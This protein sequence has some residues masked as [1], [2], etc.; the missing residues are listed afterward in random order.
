MSQVLA[1][2]ITG[3]IESTHSGTLSLLDTLRE[4]A[5][6]RSL[7]R[8]AVSNWFD[9]NASVALVSVP[10]QRNTQRFFKANELD[11]AALQPFLESAKV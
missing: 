3:R 7:E 4:N 6:N 2:Q 11:S 8:A 1:A 9:R 10:G 5:G